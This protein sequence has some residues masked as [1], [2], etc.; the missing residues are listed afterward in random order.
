MT[1]SM[2]EQT[3][4][5]EWWTMGHERQWWMADNGEYQM[6]DEDRQ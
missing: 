1:D 3:I 6:M 2:D 5:I 4:G